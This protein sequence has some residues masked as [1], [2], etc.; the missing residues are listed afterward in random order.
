M[1]GYNRNAGRPNSGNLSKKFSK[2]GPIIKSIGNFGIVINKKVLDKKTAIP[3]DPR[4]EG[5]IYS[6]LD[7]IGTRSMNQTSYPQYNQNDQVQRQAR[8]WHLITMSKHP[9]LEDIIETLTDEA[10]VYDKNATYCCSAILNTLMLDEKI[11]SSKDSKDLEELVTEKFPAL[12]R[13]LGLYKSG[14][15]S[16]MQEWLV[17]GKKAWEIV[18][19]SLDNPKSIIGLVPIDPLSL[20][21]H[22]DE[23]GN[24]WWIQEPNLTQ[25]SSAMGVTRA[26][27][28]QR[29]LH[30]SQVIYWDWDPTGFKFSY[31]ERLL[32]TFNVYRA[33]ERMKVNWWV[34][35]SQF[36]TMIVI[37]THGKSRQRAAEVLAAAM[38]RYRDHVEF[39]D[40]DGTVKVN[41]SA[42][43]PANKEYWLADTSSGKPEVSTVGGDGYDLSSADTSW[44]KRNLLELS[45]V[46]LDRFDPSSSESW[47]LDPTSSRRQELKFAKFVQTLRT[48]M[49]EIMLKPLIIQIC[50]DRPN[51][52]NNYELLD[53]I[54]IDFLSENI[55]TQKIEMEIMKERTEFIGEMMDKLKRVDADGN[56]K[57]FFSLKFLM[58]KYMMLTPEELEQNAKAL[59]EEEKEMEEF[60]RKQNT[61]SAEMEAEKAEYTKEFEEDDSKSLYESIKAKRIKR[62]TTKDITKYRI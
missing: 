39:S 50:L 47:N 12:Y 56:E 8:R 53:A 44:S 40:E 43:I 51:L 59:K 20:I 29:T 55:F 6:I 46:P 28:G 11:I 7:T 61:I 33:I 4:L 41:G 13:M 34:M 2:L 27:G 25:Q 23:D 14:A 62:K 1:L 10:I 18:Y 48:S 3:E 49:S 60:S 30:D 36:R 21:E 32:R 45:K 37:P 57:P 38:Q 58:D 26:M 9:E 5:D 54:T 19:D 22:W 42:N 17:E 52:T 24:R 35:N 31:L 15:K 16:L